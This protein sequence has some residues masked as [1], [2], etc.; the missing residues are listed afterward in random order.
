MATPV[1][2]QVFRGNELVRTAQFERPVIKIGRLA[3]AHL[4][5]EDERVARLHSVIEVAG[6]GG[7]SIVDM[8][9][10][11][12]TIVNGRRVSRGPLRPGDQITLGAMRIVLAAN[13]AVNLAA[14]AP[15]ETPRPAPPAT[16]ED[17]PR[18][19]PPPEPEPVEP[20]A[21]AAS[22]SGVELRLY[23]GGTLLD[24]GTFVRP[25]S[26]VRLGEGPRCAL[27][28]PAELLP[29]PEFPVLR[30]EGGEHRLAFG[31]G[32][33]GSLVEGERSRSLAE[34][35][36]GG[37]ATPDEGEAGGVRSLPVP[38]RGALRVELGS[39]LVLEAL[40]RTPPAPAVSRA[41]KQLELRFANLFLVLLAAQAALVALAV[42]E[43]HG[44]P[45]SAEASREPQRLARWV[46][47]AEPPRRNPYLEKLKREAERS[48]DP[49]ER[50]ARHRGAEGQMGKKDA[51]RT[52]GRSA[53]R[54]VDLRSREQVRNLG[55][56]AAVRGR[57][58]Q[59]GLST[60]FGQGGL[61]G[62]IHGAIGNLFGPVVGDSRGVG[63][64]GLK[65]TG[66]GGGGA[67]DTIGIGAVGTKGRGGGLAGY[68]DGVGGLGKKGE[69]DVT[70]ATADAR[71]LGA[72]DAE[73]VRKV[74][75]DHASQ[76]RYC[77]EQQLAVDHRLAGKVSVRWQIGPDG[78][79]SHLAVDGGETTL[80]NPAVHECMM[81]RIASWE[82]PK[83]KGGGIA[84]IK[85][86]WILRSSG[87]GA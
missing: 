38:R 18:P 47:P 35:C 3:T 42:S 40:P 30:W 28:A 48:A 84:V 58:G 81:S 55:L 63:G 67:G 72:V 49:G 59:A 24:S 83:P 25:A 19:A 37:E 82:F 78:R 2:L 34:L 44:E 32:M 29:E 31:A 54:A 15:L 12:G 74:I 6:D 17:P 41:W 73:L 61:G 64:L 56:L 51:P 9:S 21:A 66:T 39:G 36:A 10:A 87:G 53:P 76:I 14:P 23:W 62:D 43:A 20:G 4:R 85:Y 16:P 71:V 77:Y 50:A 70:I 1:T 52:E 57:N 65:G 11:A 75:R 69:R 80:A 79:A 26:P 45:P 68:G 46:M 27:H 86:P 5:L 33:S 13:Q 8:G 22:P 7:L 60:I